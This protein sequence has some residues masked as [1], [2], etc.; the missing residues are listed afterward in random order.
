[1]YHKSL[2]LEC[3]ELRVLNY[4][5]GAMDTDMQGVIR[6]SEGCDEEVREYFKKS[7]EE[8]RGG[9]E[10]RGSGGGVDIFALVPMKR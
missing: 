4:A 3:P 7:K 2:A 8:V 5:P 9:G 6:G 10:E 1:M